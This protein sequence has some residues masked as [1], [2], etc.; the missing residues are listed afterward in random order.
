M[1]HIYNTVLWIRDVGDLIELVCSLSI[2]F[3]FKFGDEHKIIFFTMCEMQCLEQ[4]KCFI[5]KHDKQTEIQLKDS[6]CSDML[7]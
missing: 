6:I 3:E 7:L 1:S 5:V 4:I 2:Q